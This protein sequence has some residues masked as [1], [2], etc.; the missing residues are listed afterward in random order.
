VTEGP[1][2]VVGS[3]LMG[4]SVGLA[5]TRAGVR[6]FLEDANPSVAAVAASLGA[7]SAEPVQ[8][9]PSLVVVAVPP[10]HLG[11]VVTRT[12]SRWPRAVVTDIGSVKVR[13]LRE[14]AA[15]GEEEVRRYVGSHPMAG[16]ERSGPVAASA[17]LFDGRAWAVTPHERADPAAV[18]AVQWLVAACQAV[19]VRMTPEEHDAAVARMSHLPHVL[20]V[21]TAARLVD[22]PRD[23][24]ALA[25][26]GLRDVTRIAAGD[27]R[28]WR[29]IL[30]SNAA[31]VTVLLK[32][33]RADLDQLIAELAD[34]DRGGA[35]QGGADQG[36]VGQG[37][38][39]QGGAGQGGAGQGGVE[40]LLSR[41]VE[42][43]R[44]IP[45]KH[46][47]PPRAEATVFVVIPDRP[48]QLARLFAHTGEAGVNIED[49]RID[50][51]LGR[52]AGVVEITVHNEAADRLVAALSDRGWVA[53]R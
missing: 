16:S 33:V 8:G 9:E 5:L 15:A 49:I 48:G 36:G 43:T 20:A 3:G 47:G 35:D 50:H 53:H 32:D 44:V 52:A 18:A 25:G 42:G 2:V 45:G 22:A 26:Q 40:P 27:P 51:E 24:L 4:A 17:D 38:V 39:D 29:Q 7:G 46:G 23:Q 13:P 6:V 41:G 34:A 31:S 12:L 30:T 19:L 21:L 28:L 11:A 1:V 37:G 10:D 14:V